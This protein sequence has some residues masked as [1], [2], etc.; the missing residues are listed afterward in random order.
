MA[1]PQ[2]IKAAVWEAFT[3]APEDHMRQFAEGGDQAFLESCRGNDWCLWQDICP[4]QL[5][6]YKVDVQ[7]LGGA[8]EGVR[9]VVFHG[10][11]RPW[12]VGW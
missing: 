8:P 2:S 6:S 3:A 5:C 1:I 7:R 12:E 10:K 9:A 4:G 11:P